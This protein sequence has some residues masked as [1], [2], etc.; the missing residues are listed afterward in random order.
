MPKARAKK[1]APK[2]RA[3]APT[4]AKPRKKKTL[5]KIANGILTVAKPMA[6]VLDNHY[7]GG[8][9]GKLFQSL[10]GTGDYELNMKDVPFP[11][12]ANTVVNPTMAPTVPLIND[13][14]GATRV[15][16]REFI[17][18]IKMDS[19]TFSIYPFRLQPGDNTTFPWLSPIARNFQQYKF[20]G[21]VFEFVS[22]SGIFNSLTPALGQVILATNYNV[23]QPLFSNPTNMLNTYFSCSARPTDNVMHP[24]ECETVESPYNL[25]YVRDPDAAVGPIPLPGTASYSSA[26]DIHLFDFANFQISCINGPSDYIAGQLWVTY[27][28]MLYKPVDVD[29]GFGAPPKIQGDCKTWSNHVP[30]MNPSQVHKDSERVDVALSAPIEKQAPVAPAS[31]AGSG[32]FWGG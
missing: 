26:R 5:S 2:S 21:C 3:K 9:A 20:L 27:D 1:P 17:R 22:T 15:R 6:K 11:I 10:S 19:K 12:S 31:A 7:L 18:T 32:R 8:A 25:Y 28:I 30:I 29:I 23:S 4:K 24:V 16:H 14:R 13:D